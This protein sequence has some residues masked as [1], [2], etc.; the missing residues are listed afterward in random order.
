MPVDGIAFVC[1]GNAGRSQTATAFAERERDE[2]G[3]DIDIV[4]G[5]TEPA[6]HVHETVVEAMRERDIDIGDRTPRKITPD[7]IEDVDYV[8]TMGCSIDEFRPTDWEGESEQWDLEHPGGDSVDAVRGQRD[9]IER[10][11]RALF[12]GLASEQTSE[13]HTTEN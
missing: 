4:T 2:R 13:D 8:V 9:E 7:D 1:V 11:V 3:L 10:R 6:D 12:D 5:G